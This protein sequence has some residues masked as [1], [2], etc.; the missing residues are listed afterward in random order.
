M[1]RISEPLRPSAIAPKRAAVPAPGSFASAATSALFNVSLMTSNYATAVVRSRAE[2]AMKAIRMRTSGGT[3]VLKLEETS[4]PEPPAGHVRVKVAAAG[5]NF[6][7]VYQRTGL[8]PVPLPATPGGEGAGEV[9]ALG[10]GVKTLQKG[11]RVASVRLLGSYAEQALVPE[12][13]AVKIPEGLD[14]NQAAAAML[15]GMTAHYLVYSTFPLKPG[16]SCIVHAAAGGVGLLL[17]Q[18]AKR[19]GAHV[20]ATVSTEA[21]ARLASDAGADEV[22]LYTKQDFEAEVKKA[23]DGKGVNVVYDSVGATTWEKSLNCLAPL[24]MLVLF[25][26][27]SGVVPPFNPSLLAQKG[28]LFL[29]R[30]TLAHYTADRSRLAWRANEILSWVKEGSL[31]LRIDK[32]FPLAQAADA[33]HALEARQTTGKVL[34]VP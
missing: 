21:K 15:Q 9:V 10:A 29:T 11:D 8:Y 25:G 17:V 2:H 23:S 7:E 24:G 32:T 12:E 26:Q 18:L 22:I 30:P 1:R 20:F 34:L 5:L 28:S 13:A 4:V 3:E 19:C 6:I 33:H 31:K 27:S 16:Q 14:L